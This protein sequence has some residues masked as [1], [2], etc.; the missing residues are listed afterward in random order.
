MYVCVCVCFFLVSWLQKH[1]LALE[2]LVCGAVLEGVV[3]HVK[4]A[5]LL[6]ASE[7]GLVQKAGSLPDKWHTLVELL[8]NRDPEGSGL[9]TFLVTSFPMEYQLI[10]QYGM[11]VCVC[12][13]V[14]VC[15]SVCMHIYMYA[16]IFD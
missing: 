11:C 2:C 7:T 14:C 6:T 15:A 5:G 3:S 12:V 9:K 8:S 13:C 1:Q 10:C 16:L 4:K